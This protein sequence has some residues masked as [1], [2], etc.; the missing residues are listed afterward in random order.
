MGRK[1]NTTCPISHMLPT[2]RVLRKNNG[3][4]TGAIDLYLVSGSTST[5]TS[6]GHRNTFVITVVISTC[7]F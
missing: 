7:R 6:I 4:L 1:G 3:T 5:D 2:Q